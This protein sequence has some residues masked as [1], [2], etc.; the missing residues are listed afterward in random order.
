MTPRSTLRPAAN[1]QADGALTSARIDELV[2]RVS[3][4]TSGPEREAVRDE[5]I[6]TLVPVARRIASKYRNINGEEQDDLFQVAC[7]GLVKA[8]D[9]YVPDQ[10]HAFLSYA[11][12]TITG[13]LKRHLRDRSGVVRLPRAVQEARQRVRRA[14]L[15]LEQEYGG[16]PP[17]LVEIALA[18]GL[19]ED[20]VAKT[21]HAE[22]ASRPRSLDAP[23]EG[24]DRLLPALGEA[25]GEPDPGIE[26]TAERI[27]LINA[28]KRF[29][30]RERRILVLR[31]VHDQ[32]Q[33]QIAST[34]GVS[35]MHVSRLLTRC[36]GQLRELLGHLAPPLP[37]QDQG[38]PA[39]RPNGRCR[40]RSRAPRLV[41]Q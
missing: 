2:T 28:L 38:S 4:Q 17:T 40:G 25:M 39:R 9:G 36:L 18:C 16:R 6:R 35:Q 13:E 41:R 12:P 34:V 37:A 10:G 14:R 15:E 3:E 7:E 20:T 1:P 31:F 19:P 22:E 11:V 32:T 5:A 27:E 33:Q 23:A 26:A 29:P 21:I 24:M 30:E 8:I